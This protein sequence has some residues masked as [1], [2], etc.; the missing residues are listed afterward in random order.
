MYQVMQF[1]F[2]FQL[3]QPRALQLHLTVVGCNYLITANLYLRTALCGATCFNLVM[4]ESPLSK[5]W[6]DNQAKYNIRTAGAS[7]SWRL[8]ATHLVSSFASSVLF[9]SFL[10][11]SLFSHFCNFKADLMYEVVHFAFCRAQLYVFTIYRSGRAFPLIS[12]DEV[13]GE[14]LKMMKHW[15]SWNFNWVKEGFMFL[16]SLTSEQI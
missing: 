5:H 15:N 4:H 2:F 10:G 9:C 7:H 3:V 1:I 13:G 16:S 11:C 14:L 8:T 6:S 12:I